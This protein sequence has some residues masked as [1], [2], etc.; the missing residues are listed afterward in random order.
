MDYPGSKNHDEP[1]EHTV[2]LVLTGERILNNVAAVLVISAEQLGQRMWKYCRAAVWGSMIVPDTDLY[3][4]QKE[5]HCE[6]E[7]V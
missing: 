7:D 5:Q 6:G 4:L 2:R 3:G 1:D